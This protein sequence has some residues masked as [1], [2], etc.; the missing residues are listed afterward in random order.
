ME[1]DM[2]VPR[3]SSLK[4]MEGY[5]RSFALRCRAAAKSCRKK[6]PKR[7]LLQLAKEYDEHAAVL[8]NFE[9]SPP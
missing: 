8:A 6:D 9:R 7:K 2:S 5:Y 1:D 3:V 4:E